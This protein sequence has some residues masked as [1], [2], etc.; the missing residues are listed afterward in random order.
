MKQKAPLWHQ[1]LPFVGLL[2]CASAGILLAANATLGSGIFLAACAVALMVWVFARRSIGIY[3]AVA[4]AFGALQVW[5]TRESPAANLA[6]DIEKTQH[7]ATA[8]GIVVGE[9]ITYQ[10]NKNRNY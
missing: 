9:P 5:Q 4:A 10:K 3:L 2:A 1:R 7:I 8:T 6:R